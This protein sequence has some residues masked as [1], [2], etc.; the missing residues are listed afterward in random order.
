MIQ[1]VLETLI[2]VATPFCASERVPVVVLPASVRVSVVIAMLTTCEV[3]FTNVIVVPTGNATEAF[4][5]IVK[6]RA[7]LSAVGCRMC[8]PASAATAVYAVDWLF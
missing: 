5:G 4:A 2:A 7:L 1:D 3:W 8:P 6:V